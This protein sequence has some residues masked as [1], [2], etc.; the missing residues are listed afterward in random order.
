MLGV[1]RTDF[2]GI[3][4]QLSS[5]LL[6]RGGQNRAHFVGHGVGTRPVRCLSCGGKRDF[7]SILD[8]GAHD[9]LL[10]D[11][12]V[13]HVDG[14]ENDWDGLDSAEREAIGIY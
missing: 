5:I 4:G 11:A 1:A 3:C 10:D 9:L 2:A 8:E 14:K 7:L 13:G 12:I 6:E